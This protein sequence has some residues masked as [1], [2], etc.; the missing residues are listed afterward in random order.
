MMERIIIK[1]KNGMIYAS[2]FYFL[3]K[4]STFCIW[5]LSYPRI[6]FTGSFSPRKPSCF[7][8]SFCSSD[9]FYHVKAN[10]LFSF[11]PYPSYHFLLLIILLIKHVRLERERERATSTNTNQTTWL[12]KLVSK[13][14]ASQSRRSSVLRQIYILIQSSHLYADNL[15]NLGSICF[16]PKKINRE[17]W[18]DMRYSYNLVIIYEL[19][20]AS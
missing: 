10:L 18:K 4:W 5:A 19:Y 3:W 8:A 7:L 12:M 1:K 17:K 13:Q 11:S 16:H 15:P 2:F 20:E 6:H 14:N 9:I